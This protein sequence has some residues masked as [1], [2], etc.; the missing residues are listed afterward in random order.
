MSLKRLRSKQQRLYYE[1]ANKER[2][3][4]ELAEYYRQLK[5]LQDKY[6]SYYNHEHLL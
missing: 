6:T 5:E 2:L 1:H 4:K 3:Q